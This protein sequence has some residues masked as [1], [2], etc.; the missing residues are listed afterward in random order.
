MEPCKLMAWLKYLPGYCSDEYIGLDRTCTVCSF[1]IVNPGLA[2]FDAFDSDD[3]RP[4][5][6]EDE[7]HAIFDCVGYA[8]ARHIL[9]DFSNAQVGSVAQFLW[10]PDCNRIAKFLTEIRFLRANSV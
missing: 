1:R 5:P 3:E 6:V 2:H 8:S 10:K 4:D 9:Q 7:Q